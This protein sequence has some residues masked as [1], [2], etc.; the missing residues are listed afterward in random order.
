MFWIL[1]LSCGCIKNITPVNDPHSGKGR[2]VLGD[3]GVDIIE[4]FTKANPGIGE[5]SFT[6]SGTTSEG[7]T[8]TD[9]TIEFTHGATSDYAYFEA[10]HYTLTAVYAPS[11]ANTGKGEICFAGTSDSFDITIGGTTAVIITVSP[12]NAKVSVTFDESL[13][14]LYTAASVTLSSQGRDDV[15][16]TYDGSAEQREQYAYFAAGSSITYTISATANS[17]N[18]AYDATINGDINDLAAGRSFSLGVKAYD[19]RLSVDLGSIG[20]S[21]A[22]TKNGSNQLTG[23]KV[24]IDVTVPDDISASP[25]TTTW[26]ATVKDVNGTTYRTLNGTS[27]VSSE[28]MN[29][30]DGWDYLPKGAY[31][32]EVVYSIDNGKGSIERIVTSS[33]TS[34]APPDEIDFSLNLTGSSSYD[35]YQDGNITEANSRDGKSIY[36]IGAS[37]KSGLAVSNVSKYSG[38]FSIKS[39]LDGNEKS[40]DNS[41]LSLAP[42]TI[43][44]TLTFDGKEYNISDSKTVHVTGLPFYANPPKEDYWNNASWNVKFD[45]DNVQLGAVSGSGD[46]KITLK[47]GNL[48]VPSDVNVTSTTE[49]KMKTYQFFG[50]ITTDYTCKISG[51]EVYKLQSPPKNTKETDLQTLINKNV[52]LK[53]SNL[54]VVHSSSYSAAGPYAKVYKFSLIYR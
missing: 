11:G 37:Y 4:E 41:N 16:L 2:I 6:I 52:V 39:Y 38:L 27:T 19:K 45:S 48:Y 13:N 28:T 35:S 54:E 21:V 17:T 49:L 46:P 22:H 53:A 15:V 29:V 18:G 33:I 10:G 50:Y 47:D 20:S 7:E 8:V 32:L 43:T 23:T 40:G 12:T 44:G 1:L 31:T 42:H 26:V 34:P 51:T 24:A 14:S 36:G 25:F 3:C 9:Q 5:L 30:S